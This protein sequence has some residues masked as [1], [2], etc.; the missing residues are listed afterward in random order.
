MSSAIHVIDCGDALTIA[1]VAAIH[2]KIQEALKNSSNIELAASDVEKVDTAGLQVFVALQK[3]V[4]KTHGQ[5]IWKNPSDALR[6]AADTLGLTKCIS[7][8]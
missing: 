3:E 1:N 8:D 6:K 2:H 7:L 4:E 5:L